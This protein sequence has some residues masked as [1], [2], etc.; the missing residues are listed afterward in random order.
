MP[1]IYQVFFAL[2]AMSSAVKQDQVPDTLHRLS[3]TH[4]RQ[5]FAAHTSDSLLCNPHSVAQ[6][7]K[8]SI[9]HI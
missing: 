4:H 1:G 9:Q 8:T 2:R 3:R 5:D 6:D 7:R